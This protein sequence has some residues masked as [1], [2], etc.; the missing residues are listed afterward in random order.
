MMAIAGSNTTAHDAKFCL[1]TGHLSYRRLPNGHV[2]VAEL[3]YSEIRSAAPGGREECI[4]YIQRSLLNDTGISAA[5]NL[6]EMGLGGAFEKRV[7]QLVKSG[8]AEHVYPDAASK[9]DPAAVEKMRQ[10]LAHRDH[11]RF[12]G[13]GIETGRTTVGDAEP[14]IGKNFNGRLGQIDQQ[15]G[16][17]PSARSPGLS[18]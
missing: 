16:A 18:M 9:P 13:L 12:D 8:D 5:S 14:A 1:P 7:A 6:Y 11:V 4:A 17:E 2:Q 15:L 10:F 3:F